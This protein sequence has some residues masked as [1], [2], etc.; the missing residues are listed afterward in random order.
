MRYRIIKTPEYEEWLAEETLK[1]QVQIEKRISNIEMDGHFGTIKD[2]EDE[3]WELK[4]VG[5]RRIYYAYIPVAKIVLLL[6]GNKNGQSNDIKKARK[7]LREYT[8][9]EN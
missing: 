3:L 1:S 6:G 5:G 2:L 7:I 4:W 9:D 8:K